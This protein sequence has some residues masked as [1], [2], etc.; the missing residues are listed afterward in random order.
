MVKLKQVEVLY[1]VSVIPY[2]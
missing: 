2:A 1:N